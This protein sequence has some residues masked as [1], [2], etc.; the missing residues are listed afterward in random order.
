MSYDRIGVV[1]AAQGK[2]DDALQAHQS[3]LSILE[4]FVTAA[5]QDGLDR[6]RD[7]AVTLGQ[8]GDVLVQQGK[9]EEALESYR[10]GLALMEP[11]LAADPNNREWRLDIVALNRA[12]AMRGDDPARRFELIVSTLKSINSFQRLTRE[13]TEWLVEAQAGLAQLSSK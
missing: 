7:L 3:A 10:R 5:D 11:V 4:R 1:F 2:L 12:L 8:I 9:L 6:Q 13:Q